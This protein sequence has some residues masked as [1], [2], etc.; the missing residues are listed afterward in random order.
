MINK[1]T[2]TLTNRICRMLCNGYAHAHLLGNMCGKSGN[3]GTSAREHNTKIKDIARNLGGSF[4]NGGNDG[5]NDCLY[6]CA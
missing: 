1:L 5:A 2:K 3:V 6:G 4:L